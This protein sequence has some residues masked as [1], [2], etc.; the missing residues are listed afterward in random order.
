MMVDDSTNK[1]FKFDSLSK[2]LSD[3]TPIKGF[4]W[5]SKSTKDDKFPNFPNL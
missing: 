3:T 5:T 4:D 2:F 1:N